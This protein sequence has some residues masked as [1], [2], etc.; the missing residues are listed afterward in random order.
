M[1][2]RTSRGRRLRTALATA[3][4]LAGALVVT[5]QASATSCVQAGTAVQLDITGG[6][7]IVLYQSGGSLRW[8]DVSNP[9]ATAACGAATLWNTNTVNVFGVNGS[10]ETFQISDAPSF[11]PGQ[12][13]EGVGTSEI[14]FNVF[15]GVGAG[16][17]Q[18]WV[19]GNDAANDTLSAGDLGASFN[20]DDDRDIL[21]SSVERI[22]FN[23]RG[24]NDVLTGQGGHGAG[25]STAV[26]MTVYGGSGND[27]INGGSG[28]D[29]LQG[30]DGNDDIAGANGNDTIEGGSGVDDMSGKKGN[31]VINSQDGVAETVR[32]N[33]G[34][35]WAHADASDDLLGIELLF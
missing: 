19:G 5:G 27:D 25:D 6:H 14:E 18:V 3:T 28:N 31:D 12:S 34:T 33:A 4:V 20:A 16:T 9:L 8:Y 26:A 7:D 24:G 30:H 21:L 10:S 2:D 29:N 15:L 35:D 23:G 32:G 11:A 17:D 22:G 13:P 1:P